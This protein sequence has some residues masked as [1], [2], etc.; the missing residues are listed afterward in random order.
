MLLQRIDLNN[1]RVRAEVL[2]NPTF[3]GKRRAGMVQTRTSDVV[4]VGGYGDSG[5]SMATI[6]R[7]VLASGEVNQIG[8]LEIARADQVVAIKRVGTTEKMYNFGGRRIYNFGQNRELTNTVETFDLNTNTLIGRAANMPNDL[9][10]YGCFSQ[11]LSE[12]YVFIAGGIL[13][14]GQ[15]SDA[16]YVFDMDDNLWLRQLSTLPF[17][18]AFGACTIHAGSVLM[19]G[20]LF[21]ETDTA[22]D[23]VMYWKPSNLLIEL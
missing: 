6:H 10:L 23:K 5:D 3:Y 17:K 13:P 9:G 4:A 2:D 18:L 20:G 19:F 22:S 11:K 16:I 15:A 14:N 7:I 21:P 1:F 8:T 12:R